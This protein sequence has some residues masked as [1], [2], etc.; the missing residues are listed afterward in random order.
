LKLYPIS[1]GYKKPRAQR[2]WP[3]LAAPDLAK[4]IID[5]VITFS[6]PFGTAIDFKDGVGSV[7]I[8]STRSHD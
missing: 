1:L 8:A 3:M 4:K 7:R 5:D 2:G 6:T